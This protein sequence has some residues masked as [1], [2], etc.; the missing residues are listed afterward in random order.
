MVS[1]VAALPVR[2]VRLLWI[3]FHGR[4]HHRGMVRR[5]GFSE[6]L[7]GGFCVLWPVVWLVLTVAG[8]S[9]QAQTVKVDQATKSDKDT[10]TFGNGDTLTC[11]AT[12]AADFRS[13]I[14]A[15]SNPNTRSR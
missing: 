6:F 12:Q 15:E 4:N 10:I 5:N 1:P 8:A 2:F 14:S 9:M 7:H 11:K 3:R 13:E